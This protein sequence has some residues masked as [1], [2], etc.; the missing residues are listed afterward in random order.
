MNLKKF[1][2]GLGSAAALSAASVTVFAAV[3]TVVVTT[4]TTMIEN[5]P[6]WMF[7]RDLSTSTPY[8]FNTN[9]AKIGVG[10]L[11]VKPIMNINSSG[12]PLNNPNKDKFI[13]ENFLNKP[14]ADVA[15]ISYDFMIG[16][17]V[18]STKEEHFYLNVY[19]NFGSSD[20]LKFY[21]CRYNIVPTTGSTTDWTTVTFDPTQAY[22]VTTRTGVPGV[23]SPHTC[24]PVP[25][26][27]NTLSAGS[28]IRAFA[29]NVGDTS[30]NDQGL[31]GYLDNVVVTTMSDTVIYD[32]EP[33]LSPAS[34]DECKKGGWMAFNTPFFKNQG[35]CVSHMQANAHANK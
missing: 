5:T 25:A 18:N 15:S 22:P 26:D 21:D 35:E 6:G 2:A 24:P 11:Y 28:N 13:A 10:S 23:A 9:K 27:M 8:E 3:T 34:K 7:N 33:A 31:D 14:I 19:A 1:F 32:F 4:N 16:D 20:D 12:L 30:A 17:P 29:I